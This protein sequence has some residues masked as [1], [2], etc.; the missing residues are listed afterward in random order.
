MNEI[1]DIIDWVENK[2]VYGSGNVIIKDNEESR[3]EAAMLY[4]AN[5]DGGTLSE[6][7]L[8]GGIKWDQ[9]DKHLI[10]FAYEGKDYGSDG[11]IDDVL[12]CLAPWAKGKMDF[13]SETVR[14][15]DITVDETSNVV[16]H[17]KS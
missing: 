6:V 12:Y 2:K 15:W 7:L 9:A 4:G 3:A 10:I 16:V 1:S 17:V 8:K 11:S 13:T 5:R 14:A